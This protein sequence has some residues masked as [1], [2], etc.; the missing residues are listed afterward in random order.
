[1]EENNC[2]P[3]ILYQAKISFNRNDEIKTLS[4]KRKLKQLVC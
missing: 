1:M 3:K 4:N 2:Q